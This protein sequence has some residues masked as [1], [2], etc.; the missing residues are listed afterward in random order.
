MS[1]SPGKE[2]QEGRQKTHEHG[3]QKNSTGGSRGSKGEKGGVMVKKK[4]EKGNV[5]ESV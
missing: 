5:K 3:R 1:L 2:T 4:K